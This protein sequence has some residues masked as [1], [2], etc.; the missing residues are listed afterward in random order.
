MVQA[1]SEDNSNLLE[2][3]DIM[4][5]SDSLVFEDFFLHPIII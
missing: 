4:E 5:P 3:K 1:V 2:L